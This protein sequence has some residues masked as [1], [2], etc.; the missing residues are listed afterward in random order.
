ML[1]PSIIKVDAWRSRV[2]TPTILE[3]KVM[4]Q[5]LSSGAE[6]LVHADK[7]G[8]SLYGI[9]TVDISDMMD[10]HSSDE[11]RS[12][13]ANIISGLSSLKS[14]TDLISEELPSELDFANHDIQLNPNSSKSILP[15]VSVVNELFSQL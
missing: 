8:N 7:K 4:F 12:M 11:L 2:V 3:F 14:R 6:V 5:M 1:M 15:S 9:K 13:E 10:D